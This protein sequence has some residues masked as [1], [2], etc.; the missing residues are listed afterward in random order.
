MPISI[1]GTGTITGLSAGGLPDD[2]ITTAEIAGSAVTTAKLAQPM[3][4]ATA[5]TT[6]GASIDFTGIPSWAKKITIILNEVAS[7]GPLLIQLG[8]SGGIEA[9]DYI[10]TSILADNVGATT[11]NSSTIG[12]I[13]TMGAVGASGFFQIVNISGNTWI[14]SHTAKVTTAQA[15]WGG[16]SK[17]LSSTLD[18]VRVTTTSGSLSSGSANVLY[19][20]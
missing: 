20:G 19:E 13:F 10:S 11:G 9:T 1:T 7:S 15:V 16:G 5:Q 2:C 6:T 12:F 4:L 18:R 8:D 14:S 3:T 17:T